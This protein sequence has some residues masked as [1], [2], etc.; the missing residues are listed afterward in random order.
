MKKLANSDSSMD[1]PFATLRKIE[2]LNSNHSMKQKMRIKLSV[3]AMPPPI[4]NLKTLLFN[5]SFNMISLS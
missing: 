4:R 5:I 2:V 3:A 1:N